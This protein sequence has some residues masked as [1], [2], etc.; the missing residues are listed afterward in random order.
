[1]T[2]RTPHFYH[3]LAEQALNGDRITPEEGLRVLQDASLDLLPLLQ[4]AF[5]VRQH[6]FG[7]RV[8][9][10]ILNNLQNGYCPEDCRYCAQSA[11]SVAPIEKYRLKD[12]EA[13]LAEAEQAH[14]SG[15]FRYCMVLSGRGPNPERLAYMAELV[16]RIKA[17]WPMEVCLSAG[18]IDQSMASTLKAAGLDRYNHNLNTAEGHYGAI[19]HT[20]T[21]QDRLATLQAARAVGLEVCSGLI[22]G[23]GETADDLW[24]VACTLRQLQVRSIPVNFYVHIPGNP[25]GPVEPPLTPEKCLRVLCLFRFLN[26]DA[27]LRAAGGREVHLRSQAPLALYPANALFSAGYLNVGGQGTD[28]VVQMIVDAGFE[29]ELQ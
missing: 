7:R 8:R 3:H 22:V 2:G 21:Y 27:E 16:Q 14:Q 26:P 29:V 18:F 1:M 17:R 19:C 25:L 10:Q 13:I 11:D 5:R 20:H 12:E 28:E 24:T 6:Y 15:A 9:L 23:M 4:A